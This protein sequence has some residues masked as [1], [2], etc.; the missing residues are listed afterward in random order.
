QKLLHESGT[1]FVRYFSQRY[2]R[3]TEFWYTE[4]NRYENQDLSH[5]L[6]NQIRRAYKNCHV[7]RTDPQWLAANAYDC[8]RAAFERYQGGNSPQNEKDFQSNLLR[9]VGGPFDFWAVFVGE[10]LAGYSKCIVMPQHA[11]ISVFRLHPA[12]LQSYPA[13]ALMDT[14]LTSYVRENGSTMS[15]GFRSIAHGTQMQSF[16]LK[17]GYHNVYCD[18]KVVY[19][20]ALELIVNGLYAA[21]SIVQRTPDIRL[22]S[23][24]KGLLRQEEIRRSF[25]FA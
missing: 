18:L 5:K 14:M 9:D 3:P 4:C 17:F 11:S 23:A 1:L 6:K 10:E 16:V 22:L 7:H 2:T 8:Y 12:H 21:N 25:D 24:I 19:R 13:Y 15:N 20:P